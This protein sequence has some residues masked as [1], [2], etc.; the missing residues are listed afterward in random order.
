[1]MNDP[2]SRSGCRGRIKKSGV[3]S[4]ARSIGRAEMSHGED[5][6]PERRH[7]SY[8]VTLRVRHPDIDPRHI[9]AA[10]GIEPEWTWR[11]GEARR[12]RVGTPLSGVYKL[13]YWYATLCEAEYRERGLVEALNELLDR[14]SPFREYFESIRSAGGHIEFFIGWTFY[15]NSGEV[16]EPEL[17]ARLANLHIALSLDVDNIESE[18]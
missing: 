2:P 8:V 13:S 11:A 9:T 18:T 3:S 17:L 15:H 16:F 7:Y 12:T 10:L 4:H 1:M 14:L 6:E 5:E